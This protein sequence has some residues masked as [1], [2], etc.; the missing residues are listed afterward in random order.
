V[1]NGFLPLIADARKL[2]R[3][4]SAIS[5]LFAL[6]L[7]AALGCRAPSVSKLAAEEALLALAVLRKRE[8]RLAIGVRRQGWPLRYFFIEADQDQRDWGLANMPSSGVTGSRELSPGPRNYLAQRET[9]PT[10]SN[11]VCLSSAASRAR[12]R[13][14]GVGIRP[15]FWLQGQWR[16]PY[17][18]FVSRVAKYL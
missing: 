2:P 1:S 3:A 14:G 11:S 15:E 17:H 13:I 8:G 18:H 16:P 4:P 6:C 10:E 5:G 12:R 7:R 9:D